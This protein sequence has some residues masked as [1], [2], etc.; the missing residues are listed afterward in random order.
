V[1][2]LPKLMGIPPGGGNTFQQLRYLIVNIPQ[3]SMYTLAIGA[4]A[5]FEVAYEIA[6]LIQRGTA[7][8][9]MPLTTFA[10]VT[11]GMLLLYATGFFIK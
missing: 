2:Q 5:V 3:T 10:G 8:N 9:P 1:G 7:R 6:K 4:G 11:A